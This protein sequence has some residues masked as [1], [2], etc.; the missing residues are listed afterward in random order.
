MAAAVRLDSFPVLHEG[1]IRVLTA[2]R[3]RARFEAE[4][5]ADGEPPLDGD[6]E[7]RSILTEDGHNG[8]LRLRRDGYWE[9]DVDY[10][11]AAPTP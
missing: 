7:F 3:I 5:A 8:S 2:E 10:F 1:Q 6:R 11:T 4:L 9:S